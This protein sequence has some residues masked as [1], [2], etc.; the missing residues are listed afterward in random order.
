[1]REDSE[2]QEILLEDEDDSQNDLQEEND[3]DMEF[4]MELIK[5]SGEQQFVE[6]F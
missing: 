6:E 5:R 2:E 1:M 3:V 4:A